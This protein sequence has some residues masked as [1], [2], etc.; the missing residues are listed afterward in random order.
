M[1]DRQAEEIVRT[2]MTDERPLSVNITV[3]D[4]WILVSAIQLATRHPAL[5]I[6]M[7]DSLFSSARMFQQQVEAA[8]PESHEL[9]EM[10]WD[11][12]FD[13]IDSLDELDSSPDSSF[14]SFLNG[15][16]DFDDD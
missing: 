13:G 5:S 8:H 9:I 10:G 7:K 11:I 4:A 12:R 16:D 2:C 6:Y 15:E 3:K 1:N 14:F